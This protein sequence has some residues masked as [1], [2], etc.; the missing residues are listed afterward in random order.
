MRYQL[1]PRPEL[2]LLKYL[3]VLLDDDPDDEEKAGSWR[4]RQGDSC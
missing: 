3:L 2:S 1:G 4:H